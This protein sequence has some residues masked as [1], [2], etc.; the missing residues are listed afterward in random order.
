MVT[1][2]RSEP[3]IV[4]LSRDGNPSQ[5]NMTFS[6][7]GGE[8]A[9]EPDDISWTYHTYANEDLE[10]IDIE[11]LA[12]SSS[13][14]EFSYDLRTL[15]IFNLSLSDGGVFT[16]SAA[17]VAGME[18]ASQELVIYGECIKNIYYT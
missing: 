1:P 11:T 17:N 14:Y 15:T 18:S 7:T 12:R 10:A 6:I 16:F 3:L 5:V 4:V 2:V 9:V 8:S 13:K